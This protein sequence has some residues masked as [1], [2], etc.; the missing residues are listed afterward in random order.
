MSEV[1]VRALVI[2][3]GISGMTA[4]FALANNYLSVSV[5]T[6]FGADIRSALIRKVQSFSFANLDRLQTGKLIVRSTSDINMVQ[7]IVLLSLR[8]L[9]R[10]PIWAIG[11]IVLLVFT[12]QRL[13]LIMA[14][15]VPLIVGL[16]LLFA[17]KART[18][19]LLVQQ[20][21]DRLNTVLQENLAGMRIR[22]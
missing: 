16:V 9:T 6:S 18:M 8:I 10:A 7:M 12:S 22:L 4:A 1:Q 11:A 2:G 21:L 20:R 5:A 14:V 17:R 15:F 13:A 19:F 3:G